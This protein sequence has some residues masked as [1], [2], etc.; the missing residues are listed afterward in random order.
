MHTFSTGR[1]LPQLNALPTLH[2]LHLKSLERMSTLLLKG[3]KQD[4]IFIVLCFLEFNANICARYTN[5]TAMFQWVA[6]PQHTELVKEFLPID[7]ILQT[8]VESDMKLF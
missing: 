4:L 1:T 6:G 8:S 3:I 7:N 2:L 5:Q